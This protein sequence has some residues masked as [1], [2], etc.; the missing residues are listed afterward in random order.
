MVSMICLIDEK[1]F[2][3]NGWFVWYYGFKMSYIR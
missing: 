3:G 1:I 2:F